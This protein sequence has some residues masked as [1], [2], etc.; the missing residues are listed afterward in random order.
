[1]TRKQF[2]NDFINKHGENTL[3]MNPLTGSVE[4]C[5]QWCEESY[6]FPLTDLLTLVA[7]KYN[8]QTNSFEEVE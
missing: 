5:H 3:M 4:T 6:T 2:I 8:S 7:V 1:M